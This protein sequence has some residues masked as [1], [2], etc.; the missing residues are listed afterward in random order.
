MNI[1]EYIHY[2]K[3]A[4]WFP[5]LMHKLQIMQLSYCIFVIKFLV[6]IKNI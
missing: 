1:Y 6:H 4:S 2:C 5:F 3:I